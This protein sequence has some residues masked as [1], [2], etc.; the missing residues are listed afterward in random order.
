MHASVALWDFNGRPGLSA[1]GRETHDGDVVIPEPFFVW[2]DATEK[3]GEDVAVFIR[4][5]FILGAGGCLGIGNSNKRLPN[6]CARLRE[7]RLRLG[8]CMSQVKGDETLD[9]GRVLIPGFLGGVEKPEGL[10]CPLFIGRDTRYRP[11]GKLCPR[12]QE[13]HWIL[14]A[15]RIIVRQ[16]L[17]RLPCLCAARESRHVDADVRVAFDA[18]AKPGAE[19]VAIRQEEKVGSM[20]LRC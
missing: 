15:P 13:Q 17:R 4:F 12:I 5:S 3:G 20:A 8:P 1:V 14:L 7:E 2:I 18:A 9:D 11:R 6:E 19:E 10:I 16:F